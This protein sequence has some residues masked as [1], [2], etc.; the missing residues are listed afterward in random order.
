MTSLNQA[1]QKVASSATEESCL[2]Q[3][4]EGIAVALLF[5]DVREDLIATYVRPNPDREVSERI[6]PVKD[7]C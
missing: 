5:T 3:I 4:Q 2:E 7:T 1:E 6:L